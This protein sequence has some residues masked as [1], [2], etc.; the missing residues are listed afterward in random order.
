MLEVTGLHAWYGDSHILHDIDLKV[1]ERARVAI[2][3]RNGAGKSSLFAMLNGT[4]HEDGG[5]FFIP[6]QWRMAQVAQIATGYVYYVSLKGVTGAGN[7]DTDAV[8]KMLP[9][10]RQHVSIPVGVGF[11][12]RDAHT[13]QAVGA[14]ADAVVIG[15]KIIQLIETQPRERVVPVVSEF[16]AGIR[17]ALDALPASTTSAAVN[18][19]ADR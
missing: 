18:N 14:T 3:G 16:L 2:L 1:A 11:G 7:L 6:S 17:E 12:I 10:I 5:E 15:T 13:A 4:L 19:T 8:R 9:R